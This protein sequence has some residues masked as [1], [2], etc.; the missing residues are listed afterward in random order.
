MNEVNILMYYKQPG[1]HQF[2]G[3]YE[4]ASH[5]YILYEFWTGESLHKL[6]KQGVKF[7]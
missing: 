7:G 4:D 5:L 2:H 1:L 3:L 6:V